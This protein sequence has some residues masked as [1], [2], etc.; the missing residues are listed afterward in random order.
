MCWQDGWDISTP[1]GVYSTGFQKQILKKQFDNLGAVLIPSTPD[2]F[3][4]YIKSE[5][6]KWGPLVAATGVKL[7]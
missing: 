5:Q 4:A 6:A 2:E 7:D 1:P 3:L